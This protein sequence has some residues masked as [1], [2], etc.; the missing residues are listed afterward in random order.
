LVFEDNIKNCQLRKLGY[1]IYTMSDSVGKI[2]NYLES[3]ISGERRGVFPAIIKFGL[4]VISWI[5][6]GGVKLRRWLY[7]HAILRTKRLPCRVIGVG[8][9]VVGGSGKT[10]AVIAIA[11]ML[12]AHSNLRIAVISRGYGSKAKNAIVSDVNNVLLDSQKAGDE[13]YLLAHN[14]SGIPVLIGKDRFES[15]LESVNRWGTQV[16]IL[17]DGF[18]YLRLARDVS[19]I[20]I[21]ST[22]PFGLNHV[23]PRGY[24][25]EPLSALK[26]ADIILLTRT[27]QC[28]N[29][30][31]LRRQLD[32][33]A[34][35]VP[36]FESIHLP[37][38]LKQANSDQNLELSE[39][40]ERKILAVCGIVNNLSFIETLRSLKPAN[41]VPMFFPDHHEY[42]SDDISD[43]SQ[44]VIEYN[45]E[46]IVTTEKDAHK[47]KAINVCPILVLRIELKIVGNSTDKFFEL[48]K[49][50]CG[51]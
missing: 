11:K 4:L 12:T 32:R 50:K 25:R 26:N 3:I 5:C 31:E 34:P 39:I 19:I 8:N 7:S 23:L 9:I 42:T 46:M 22:R 21:D 24:L 41:I 45:A 49:Q 38:S 18:Q 16:A 20:T 43:I 33:I 36:R 29:L 51:L 10:P 1:N 48:I 6:L 13:P 14:L 35:L 44:K 47:L 28:K 15:G 2:I 37:Y 17:D 27:D 40:S 30:D